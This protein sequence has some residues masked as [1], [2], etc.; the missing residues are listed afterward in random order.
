MNKKPYLFPIVIIL[1]AIISMLFYKKSD[2]QGIQETLTSENRIVVATTIFPLF[3]IANEIA[4]EKITVINIL[5]PGASPHTF[6]PSPNTIAELQSAKIL[7]SIGHGADDWTKNLISQPELDD[8][9]LVYVDDGINIKSIQSENN[10]TEINLNST[11]EEHD[12]H[13]SEDPHYWLS[14]VNGELIAKTIEL[15]FENLDP[16]NKDTY[17]KNLDVFLKNLETV[18]QNIIKS[19]ATLPNKS[20]ITHHGAWFYFADAYGLNIQG[21]FELAPGLEPTANDIARLQSAITSKKVAAVF[22]EPQLSSQIVQS[23]IGDTGARVGVLD[24][25]GGVENRMSYI[26]LL[27]YNAQI[28]ENALK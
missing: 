5:P 18:N 7:F 24:P 11:E 12:E 21:V 23:F 16:A 28:I 13:G 4:G 1:V 25:L 19:F 22:I 8:L 6:E 20:I 14:G 10:V 15:E 26:E 9:K 17:Q 2:N 3:S 27:Q